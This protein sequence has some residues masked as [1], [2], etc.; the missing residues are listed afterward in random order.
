[1]K[2]HASFREF[3]SEELESADLGTDLEAL[4]RKEKLR[5]NIQNIEKALKKK[6]VWSE[7]DRLEKEEK[8]ERDTLKEGLNP[9][10]NFNETVAVQKW[11]ES[12]KFL[13][14]LDKNILVWENAV[15]SSS[16]SKTDFVAFANFAKFTLG[17]YH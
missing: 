7:L 9:N 8:S 5:S 17:M 12:K 6:K 14:L 4:C 16:I 1:M 10:N 15:N 11:F 2:A 13:E 3:I